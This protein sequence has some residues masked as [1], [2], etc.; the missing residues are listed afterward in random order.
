MHDKDFIMHSV[1]LFIDL[2]S[3]FKRLIIILT[4]KVSLFMICYVNYHEYE[5]TN[6]LIS[7]KFILQ[8]KNVTFKLIEE[9]NE[10]ER[11]KYQELK[12]TNENL[13]KEIDEDQQELEL[14]TRQKLDLED[15]ISG[16]QV[17]SSLFFMKPL[18]NK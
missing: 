7:L 8:E 4:E 11:K 6:K 12:V 16:S 17:F 3:I 14:L 13:Q 5:H 2:V 9:M 10:N 1:D 18:S 15:R